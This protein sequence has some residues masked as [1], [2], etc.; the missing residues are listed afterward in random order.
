MEQ[1]QAELVKRERVLLLEVETT[2]KGLGQML[3]EAHAVD[4]EKVN[5]T[6]TIQ[7]GILDTILATCEHLSEDLSFVDW[8][9]W[10]CATG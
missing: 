8:D 2:E 10:E 3:R 7:Y 1:S 9:A 4:L 6:A 5:E